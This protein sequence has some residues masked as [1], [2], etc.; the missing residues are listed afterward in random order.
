MPKQHQQANRILPSVLFIF[1]LLEAGTARFF[2]ITFS[3][4]RLWESLH[5]SNESFNRHLV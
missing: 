4:S 2:Y 1:S 3:K 5:F